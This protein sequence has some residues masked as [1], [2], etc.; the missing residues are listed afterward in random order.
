MLLSYSSMCSERRPWCT[1]NV[2]CSPHGPD[3]TTNN[4]LRHHSW[5]LAVP[6]RPS[7]DVRW[8]IGDAAVGCNRTNQE[9]GSEPRPDRRFSPRPMPSQH[10]F[11]DVRRNRSHH[12]HPPQPLHVPR[13]LDDSLAVPTVSPPL[14]SQPRVVAICCIGSRRSTL[15]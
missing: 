2:T 10:R 11:N 12:Y 6:S 7:S 1:A 13:L 4:S 15:R 9:D 3:E 5:P 8:L 14:R